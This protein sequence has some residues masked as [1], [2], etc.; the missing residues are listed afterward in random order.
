MGRA[1]RQKGRTVF[2]AVLAVIA[3]ILL[4]ALF[5]VRGRGRSST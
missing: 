1:P 2:Y 4:L 3:V 5:F